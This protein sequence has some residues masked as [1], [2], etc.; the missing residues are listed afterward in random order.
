MKELVSLQG[1]SAAY[2]GELVLENVDLSVYEKDFLGI[3]GPNGGGKTTLLRVI[4]G[5]LAPSAGSLTFHCSRGPSS[6]CVMGYL[7]Q[8]KVIDY[9][10]PIRVLDVVLSGLLAKRGLLSRFTAADRERA[11]GLLDRFNISDLADRPIGELSGG[12]MQRVFLCRALIVS[13]ELL[14]LDEPDTFVDASFA[15]DLNNILAELNRE[16]AILL[17]SH[18]VG[19]VLEAVKNIACVNR[20][21]H[22]HSGTEEQTVTEFLEGVQCGF[23]LVGH[24]DVPHTVLRRHR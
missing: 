2:N 14:I 8:F 12:Q 10:F 22:Y 18:D 19:T 23:R 24:G 4:L 1:I 9:Q 15:G 13:P 5:L 20:S 11:A 21:L 17:V 16:M 3:I 6:R 7:P